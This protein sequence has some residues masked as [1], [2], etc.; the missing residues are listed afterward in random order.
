MAK[1]GEEDSTSKDKSIY[2]KV[3]DETRNTIDKH[4]ESDKLTISQ[5]IADAIRLYDEYKS[6]PADIKALIANSKDEYGG[7]AMKVIE[8]ALYVF[9]E[10]K[11]PN[12]SLDKE[13]WNRA[14]DELN[15]ALIG[16][17]T[18]NQLISAAA[19]PKDD[20]H[21]VQKRNVGFDVIL[22]YTQK[23]IKNLTF[24][25]IIEAIKTVWEA[26]NWFY[27]VEYTKESEDQYHIMFRHHQN[28]NYSDYWG[29]YFIEL[30]TSDELSF[31]CI[32]EAQSFEETLSLIIKKG[33]DKNNK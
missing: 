16:K 25:E 23:P 30:L 1:N 9:A 7:R 10:E 11:D 6:L 21:K 22:W 20:L 24:D 29:K 33:Y 4:K 28:K 8:E 27:A 18:F 19:A 12:K 31:K 3:S 26:A 13:L 17:T 32:V 15:M 14:R 5:I 2:V